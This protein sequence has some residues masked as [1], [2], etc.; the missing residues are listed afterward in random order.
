MMKLKFCYNP[1]NNPRLQ[2][3]LDATICLRRECLNETLD[4]YSTRIGNAVNEY[5]YCYFA[6]ELE[7][8]DPDYLGSG[9]VAVYDLDVIADYQHIT[10]MTE[11][12]FFRALA[13]AL[14]FHRERFSDREWKVIQQKMLN[15][16]H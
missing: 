8:D 3:F 4:N 10:V 9:S 14:R 6:S 5:Q 2:S 16:L 7:S 13:E 1:N 12:Q 15:L 11:A